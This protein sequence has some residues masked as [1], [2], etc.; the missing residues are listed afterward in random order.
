MFKQLKIT[1]KMLIA[2]I[3]SLT[4]VLI[5]GITVIGWQSA[6]VTKTLSVEQAKAVANT[7]AANVKLTLEHGLSAARQLTKTLDSLKASGVADRKVWSRI[8]HNTLVEDTK[9]SGTW[10]VVLNDQVDG[11][12]AEYVNTETHDETGQWRPYYFRNPDGSIGAQATTKVDIKDKPEAWFQT[13]YETG[14]DFIGEP[15]SWAMGDKTVLGIS[16]SIPIKDAS[17]KTIG[18]AGSDLILNSLSNDLA[19]I[20]PLETGSIHLISQGGKWLAH[21]DAKLLGKDWDTARSEIDLAHKSDLLAAVKAGTN[22]EYYGYSNSLQTDV[23][24]IIQPVHFG[25]SGSALA[26]VVNVPVSTLSAAS[27]DMI[28]TVALV[29]LCLL[30]AVAAALYLVGRSVIRKPMATTIE[31]IKALIARKYD[32]PLS[33]LDRNDEVGE[34]NKALEVF[35]EKSQQAENLSRIQ[36]Q[37]QNDRIK[38][39]DQMQI[40]TS[41]FDHTVSGLLDSVSKLVTDLNQTAETLS[42]GADNTSERSNAVAAASEQASANVRTVAAAAE[43]LFTSVNEIDRQVS[44]SNKIAVDAVEQARETNDKIEGLTAAAGRIGEVVRLITDIAEQTNLLALNATIEAAR[45]GE[46]GRGF[47]VVAAEVKELATQTSKATDEI[48]QQIQA[49]QTETNGAVAAIRTIAATIDKM[50]QIS[51]AI[52]D[53][54]QQ[55][56]QATKE[57]AHNIQE[58]SSGTQEVTDNIT[59]VSTSARE[60]GGAARQVNK[61]AQE[62]QQ[63]AQN[64]KAG[65]Q[66]FLS[67]VKAVG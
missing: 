3:S 25:D 2:S 9:L 66:A 49:V 46:A 28:L 4:L 6:N 42:L 51:N 29:G 45:A 38:R 39:A 65:V 56:G 47:A 14:R 33:Y 57:I 11:K 58:A 54:V 50:N 24:R 1:T 23:L 61:S 64:L 53:A 48:S 34:I 27:N 26:I 35:R 52:S 40:F 5:L 37:E 36:E 15:Y 19:A 55:Q 10:G 21:S 17:G 30:L 67:N 41:D 44:D 22:Y 59:G 63:E 43:E 7:Q 18:V 62:L 16:M 12:D 20:K 8:L 60:T 13:A 31:S 32:E